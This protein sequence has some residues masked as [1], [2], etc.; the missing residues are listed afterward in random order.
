LLLRSATVPMLHFYGRA[1]IVTD[2][3]ERRR[4][5]DAMP[6]PE[7][8]VDPDYKGAAVVV[9]LDRVEGVLRLGPDGP[10]RVQLP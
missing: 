9:A 6:E 3:A 1:R 8:K 5:W 4:I 10:V 7:R 2:E